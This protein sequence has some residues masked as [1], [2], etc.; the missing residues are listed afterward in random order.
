MTPAIRRLITGADNIVSVLKDT[1]WEVEGDELEE[2]I[3]ET[4][5]E[6]KEV[7]DVLKSACDKI[8]KFT[9]LLEI[10]ATDDEITDVCTAINDIRGTINNGW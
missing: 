8:T 4:K 10:A 7:R 9:N 5:K 1:I 2:N 6:I 3:K